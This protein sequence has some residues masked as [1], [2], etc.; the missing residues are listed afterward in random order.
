MTELTTYAVIAT[1]LANIGYTGS[2]T[3]P[4]IGGGKGPDC[5]H[6]SST[7][8]TLRV[9]VRGRDQ[10]GDGRDVPHPGSLPPTW[11]ACKGHALQM[12]AQQVPRSAPGCEHPASPT[13][14]DAASSYKDSASYLFGQL[15]PYQHTS[16]H[17]KSMASPRSSSPLAA[18][19][20]P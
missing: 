7:H 15:L 13:A 19:V 10:A 18:A 2:L 5:F 3:G 11:M 17:W 1:K 6:H 14:S 12:A 8:E 20:S 16:P 4:T 9:A